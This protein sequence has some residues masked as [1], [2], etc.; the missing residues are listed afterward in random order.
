MLTVA[1][2]LQKHITTVWKFWLPDMTSFNDTFYK[3][4][5]YIKSWKTEVSVDKCP[6]ARVNLLKGACKVYPTSF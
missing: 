1:R 2:V 6:V 3:H 4:V 5:V